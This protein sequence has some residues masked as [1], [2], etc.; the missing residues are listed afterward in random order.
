MPKK[1]KSF[2]FEKYD[3][4]EDLKLPKF[5]PDLVIPLKERKQLANL[6]ESMCHW[7]IGDPVGDSDFHFCGKK[8]EKG[9]YCEFH[10]KRAYNSS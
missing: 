9:R 4:K 1:S 2:N 6:S 3:P 10:R 8:V 5:A 7:P